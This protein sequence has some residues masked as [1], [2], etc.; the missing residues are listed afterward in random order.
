MY[1]FC[2]II[3]KYFESFANEIVRLNSSWTS[4]YVLRNSKTETSYTFVL[5]ETLVLFFIALF[6]LILHTTGVYALLATEKKTNQS[7]LLLFVSI[8]ELCSLTRKIVRYHS[9]V[10]DKTS[11]YNNKVYKYLLGRV[12]WYQHEAYYFFLY[13]FTV[14]FLLMMITLTGERLVFALSPIS[15][16]ARVEGSLL[17]KLIFITWIISIILCGISV[18]SEE[19]RVIIEIG[20][21]SI[22]CT[23]SNHRI[24]SLTLQVTREK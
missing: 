2:G 23:R 5:A 22:G 13:F 4:P 15:Y 3:K 8:S 19:I 24:N 18:I 20:I 14:E 17:K 9:F 21:L 6:G 16:K 10:T 1:Y 7:L 11:I 12:I